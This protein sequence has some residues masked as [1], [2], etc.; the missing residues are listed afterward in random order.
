MSI[1]SILY[2]INF[3]VNDIFTPNESFYAEAVREMFESGNFLDINYNYEPRYNKPPL[4]YWII[5]VSSSIFG[6]NEFGIRLPIVLMALGSVWLTYLLGKKLYGPK[7]GI[8]ALVIMS[9][10][11]QVSFVKQYAS[12]EIPLTFFF[13]LTSYWF[14]KGYL[15][16]NFRY[17][18]SAYL[19]LGLTVLTKGFPYIIVIAGIITLFILVDSEFQWTKIWKQIKLLKLHIGIPIVLLI[20]LSWVIFMVLKDGEAFWTVYKRETFERALSRPSRGLKPFFYIE[21]IAWSMAPYSLT[22]FH[23]LFKQASSKKS[24]KSIAFPFSWFIVML[25]LFTLAKGKLP[26]YMIQAHPA[27]AL[28]IAS[29]LINY[30]PNRPIWKRF[31]NFTM[32]FPALLSVGLTVYAIDQL[33]LSYVFYLIPLSVIAFFIVGQYRHPKKVAFAMPFWSILGFYIVFSFFLPRMEAFRPYDQIG[34]VVASREEISPDTP[35]LL[36]DWLIH[37]IPFYTQRKAIRDVSIKEINRPDGEKLAL[38]RQ[39]KLHQ[40]DD[41]EVLW[42]GY[43]YD[44]ASES[45]FF[46]FGMAVREAEKGDLSKF[47]KFSLVFRPK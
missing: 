41:F 29:V 36:N 13:T 17:I 33:A 35:V 8:Y 7:A 27:M 47:D 18:L 43:I 32:Y 38:V 16:R 45:Q 21:V 3:N 28:I 4:T 40:L 22:F 31:W 9:V 23:A 25:V 1:I 6:L 2:F 5:A 12:P 42:T 20:G 37:N 19:A 30:K 15:D 44:Y 14:V 26:T 34:E 10:G 24:I 46:K 39:S 11:I